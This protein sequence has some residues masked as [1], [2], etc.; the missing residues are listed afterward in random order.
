MILLE[1]L[2]I[3]Y[4]LKKPQCYKSLIRNIKILYKINNNYCGPFIIYN[5]RKGGNKNSHVKVYYIPMW[6]L[7]PVEYRKKSL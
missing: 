5:L 3:F 4:S 7:V 6:G 1:S 2:L